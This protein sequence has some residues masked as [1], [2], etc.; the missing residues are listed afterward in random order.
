MAEF[1]QGLVGKEAPTSAKD[2]QAF[3]DNLPGFPIRKLKI[4][5]GSSKPLLVEEPQRS[6]LLLPG[7][8]RASRGPPRRAGVAEPT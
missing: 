5:A 7:R 6:C 1:K 4:G 3:D 2:V 8:H